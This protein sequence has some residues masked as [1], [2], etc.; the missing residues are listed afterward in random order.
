MF[1]GWSES[2]G[3]GIITNAGV[4]Y[5]TFSKNNIANNRVGI[6]LL[7]APSNNIIAHNNFINNEQ[8]VALEG[9][10]IWD[11]GYPSGGNF[12][13]NYMYTD[14]FSGFNQNELGSDGIGDVPVILDKNNID[15]FPLMAPITPFDAGVWD[16]ETYDVDVVSNSTA[17]NFYF[18]PD[19]GP[20]LRFNV[21]GENGTS[22]FCRVTIPKDLLWTEDGW[23]IT[24]GDQPITDYT[25]FED[26]NYT[27]LYFT[28]NHST[29]HIVLIQG[30][31]VIPEIP[32][33]ITTAIFT[34]TT[35]IATTLLKTKRKSQSP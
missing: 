11:Y 2:G 3:A 33:I 22:G 14:L 8:Q 1:N 7:G 25:R 24:I 29:P 5:N 21:M 16:G 20:F 27:Y 34:L 23:T 31:S 10:N 18:N 12:W 6:D 28:Y 30:T 9:S 26:E 35:L 17:T 13:S 32:S 4:S 15:R 19:D